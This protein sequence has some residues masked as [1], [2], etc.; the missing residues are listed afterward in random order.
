MQHS[1]AKSIKGKA[2]Q[3]RLSE[4][5]SAAETYD[6]K[7]W[8]ELIESWEKSNESQKDFCSRMNIRLGTFAHWRGV[9]TKER[10]KENKFIELQ[11]KPSP[12][13]ERINHFKIECPSGHKIIFTFPIN[14]EEVQRIFKCLGLIA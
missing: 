9:F 7:Y 3:K 8:C 14:V 10:R 4:N 1:F 13:E 12:A 6:K 11:V 2:M 5:Q